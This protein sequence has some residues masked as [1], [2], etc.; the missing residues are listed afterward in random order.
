MTDRKPTIMLIDDNRVDR[1]VYERVIRRVGL[2]NDA[3]SFAYATDALDY[4]RRSECQVDLILLDINMPRMDGF[5]FLAAAQAEFGAK[6][7]AH[8]VIMLTT[9]LNPD[10]KARAMS[11]DVVQ[12]FLNKPLTSENLLDLAAR[13]LPQALPEG[14]NR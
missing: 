9:S 7:S 4:L 6:F 8:V 14:A 3:L 10:D 13:F 2:F 1:M 12:D 11:Y 5:E